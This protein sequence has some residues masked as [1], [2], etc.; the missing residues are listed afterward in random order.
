MLTK[1]FN[2]VVCALII[3]LTVNKKTITSWLWSLFSFKCFFLME[4]SYI[5]RSLVLILGSPAL[6]EIWSSFSPFPETVKLKCIAFLLFWGPLFWSCILFFSKNLLI[7]RRPYK[8]I[9]CFPLGLVPLG[10]MTECSPA[11]LVFCIKYIQALQGPCLSV[12]FVGVAM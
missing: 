1:F 7:S 4:H 6:M 12:G 3:V 11:F 5:V 2:H 9:K 10:R 8:A